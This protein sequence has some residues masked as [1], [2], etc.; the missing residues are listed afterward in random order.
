[1]EGTCRHCGHPEAYGA[2]VDPAKLRNPVSTIL[3]ARLVLGQTTHGYLQLQKFEASLKQW[4]ESKRLRRDGS[5]P[6]RDTVR[7]FSL[8]QIKR[9]LPR[10]A[11]TRDLDWGVPVPLEDPDARGK[12]LYVWF[13]APIGY[14]SFTAKLCEQR[15]G[16]WQADER[17]WKDPACRIVRFIGEGNI[18]FHAL[19]W[20]AML[21]AESSYPLSWP[22]VANAFLNIKRPAKEA[23]NLSKSRGTAS[24]SAN[25]SKRLT[26]IHCDSTSRPSPL[27]ISKRASMLA[28]SRNATMAIFWR[29]LVTL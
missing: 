11:M 2:Q 13:D 23:E 18:V 14:V 1:M 27:R 21:M 4:L 8:G 28:V 29:L 7:N 3:G 12:V 20:P 19:I 24:G 9:G 15:D 22:V 10:R 17:W 26:P 6:W 16:D 5:P 25:I